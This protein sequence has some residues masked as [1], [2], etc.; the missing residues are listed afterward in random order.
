MKLTQLNLLETIAHLAADHIE[1]TEQIAENERAMAE[2]EKT[3][4]QS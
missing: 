3:I 4:D 1:D 2:N